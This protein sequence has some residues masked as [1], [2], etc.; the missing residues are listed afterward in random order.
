MTDEFLNDAKYKE[1]RIKLRIAKKEN[2]RL[3]TQ[4][5]EAAQREAQLQALLTR[6]KNEVEEAHK[7][8]D[9]HRF[10]LSG[11]QL[12]LKARH[13]ELPFA[14]AVI[15]ALIEQWKPPAAALH[16]LQSVRENLTSTCQWTQDNKPTLDPTSWIALSRK[17]GVSQDF[18]VRRV[19]VVSPVSV[20]DQN[21]LTKK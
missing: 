6:R 10:R 4:L 5:V 19:P 7:S 9:F 14:V 16:S 15:D 3:V 13:Y 18:Q 17:L 8:V 21:N 11:F 1:L 20:P 2:K 12:E